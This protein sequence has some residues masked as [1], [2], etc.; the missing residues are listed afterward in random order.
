MLV[1]AVVQVALQTNNVETSLLVSTLSV[2]HITE[3]EKTVT[4]VL[5]HADLDGRVTLIS[6]VQLEVSL[7]RN[8][9]KAQ[10]LAHREFVR[11]DDALREDL[12]DVI[13]I[14]N[15]LLLNHVLFKQVQP[16]DN[17]CFK[18]KLRQDVMANVYVTGV[19]V[20]LSMHCNVKIVIR[21]SLT[22][23]VLS[24]AIEEKISE[25]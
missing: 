22:L 10:L 23:S 24:N 14:K 25:L 18:K 20:L 11:M 5:F 1:P 7:P 4:Q 19:K 3:E 2:D 17:V 21:K 12:L 13:Q 6:V 8:L 15:A 9:A 16:V